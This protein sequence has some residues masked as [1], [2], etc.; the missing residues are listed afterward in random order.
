M[1]SAANIELT[2][3]WLVIP[4]LRVKAPLIPTGAVGPPGTASLTIPQNI[5][6]VGWWDGTVTD[7]TQTARE[8]APQ[9]G[10][11]G[12]AIIAGHVDSAASGPG[13]LYYLKDLKPGDTIQI[14][15]LE[16]RTSIWIVSSQPETTPKTQLPRS[17]FATTGPARLA[18][19]SCGGPFDTATGHYTDNIIVWAASTPL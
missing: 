9:P 18:L 4:A 15:N 5:H 6:D 1:S 7:G 14:V 8:H 17:L 11:P 10:Q 16:G 19:V 13:A 12:V 2:R 3:S